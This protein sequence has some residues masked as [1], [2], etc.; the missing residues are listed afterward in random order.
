VLRQSLSS[1]RARL[2]R[3]DAATNSTL[4]PMESAAASL[5]SIG[6]PR[7]TSHA[8]A[9]PV[10]ILVSLNAAPLGVR[11]QAVPAATWLL[12]MLVAI[13]GAWLFFVLM[14][15]LLNR[16]L[17]EHPT[18]RYVA[19][20]ILFATTE[21]VRTSLT[22]G[23]ALGSGIESNGEWAFRLVSGAA[24]GLALFGSLSVVLNDVEAHRAEY[25]SLLEQRWRLQI[26]LSASEV[27][28]AATRSQLLTSVRARLEEA[29]DSTLAESR[30]V[31]PSAGAVVD[32]LFLIAQEVVRPLS[33]ELFS[34]PVRLEDL[35]LMTGVPRARFRD[36]LSDASKVPFRP[37]E[38]LTLVALLA[39][40]VIMLSATLPTFVF[41]LLA[42][43]F[44][45]L[46]HWTGRHFLQPRLKSLR[47]SWR[48]VLLCVVFALPGIIFAIA[49]DSSGIASVSGLPSAILYAVILAE[50]VAWLLA[51]AAGLGLSRQRVVQEAATLNGE[52]YWHN[53]R[54]QS[55]LWVEQRDLAVSLHNDVQ[56]AL[57]A[58]ALQLK[59]AMEAGSTARDAMPDVRRLLHEALDLAVT[60]PHP[61][62]P[63]EVLSR[64]NDRWGGLIEASWELPPNVSDALRRDALAMRIIED[65]LVEFMTNS[66]KHG[67]ASA[68]AVELTIAG[69]CTLVLSMT[70][71]GLPIDAG[72]DFSGL[73]SR[74]VEALCIEH[75]LVDVHGGV[76]LTVRVP[77]RTQVRKGVRAP[78]VLVR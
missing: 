58:A 4:R 21:M 63:A 53:V 39:L 61:R 38:M 69:E 54:T 22:H 19:V 47:L 7:A 52:L 42:L 72:R 17:A 10:L 24:T 14:G 55:Q 48:I 13:A 34:V 51:L 5:L 68:V 16:T 59:R 35:P 70:N 3:V 15:R 1:S 67:K 76:R 78:T 26:A 28:L 33:H 29:I 49:I 9:L 27:R 40:P 45:F 60:T 57:V 8:V 73:G 36:L 71:N 32:A 31:V 30:K 18:Q 20:L 11:L 62:D 77:F 65:F 64:A 41:F 75:S 50:V 44:T 37:F 2:D 23:L 43:V 6:G 56:T 66:I 46:T 12:V 74:M 25:R